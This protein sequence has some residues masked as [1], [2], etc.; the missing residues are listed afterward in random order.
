MG[1][2]AHLN[3]GVIREDIDVIRRADKGPADGL[4]TSRDILQIGLRRGHASSR[5]IL[6]EA[7]VEDVAI[8]DLVENTFNV[9]PLELL[10]LPHLQ[11]QSSFL[12][13][14]GE[15]HQ[16]FLVHSELAL[17]CLLSKLSS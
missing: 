13:I 2:Q 15:L 7:T 6:V 16:D 17:L 5:H 14:L 4:I 11:D 12:I 3:L 1:G 10:Q 9:S 8:Y